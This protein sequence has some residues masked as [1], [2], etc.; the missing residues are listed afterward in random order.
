[1]NSEGFESYKHLCPSYVFFCH[2]MKSLGFVKMVKGGG[3]KNA[4]EKDSKGAKDNN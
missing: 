1:M 3:Y 4:R 2:M